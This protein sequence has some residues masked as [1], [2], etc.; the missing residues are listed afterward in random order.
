MKGVQLHFDDADNALEL[1]LKPAEFEAELKTADIF[2]LI[3][4]NG[5][6]RLYISESSVKAACEKANH[7]FKTKDLTDVVEKIGERRNAEVEFRIPEDAMVATVVLTTPYGGKLPTVDTIKK[8]AVKN[9]IKRGLGVK[10]IEALLLEA[11]SAPQGAIIEQIVAKGLPP[12]DGRPSKFVPL[13]PNALERVL[14]PQTG[15]D[16]R[17]DMRNLGE[18]ICVKANTEVLKRTAPTKGRTGFDVRGNVLEAKTGDWLDFKMGSGTEVSPKNENI[19]ISSIAGMPKYQNQVMNI[20][21]TFISNGVNVGTGHVNYE[22]A[23]LVNGDVTEKMVIKAKGDVTINGFVESAYIESGGDIIVTEGAMGKVNE[24]AAEFS[25][26]LVAAGSIH[27][28]HGQGIDLKCGQ[29]VTV[30][31]QLAYSRI[32]CGG[33][34]TVGQVDNPQGN[35]FACEIISQDKIIAGTLGAVSGSTLKVDFSSGYNL[36]LERRDALEDLLKQLRD[37]NHRHKEKIN[38]IKSKQVPAELRPRVDEVIDLYKS[39]SALLNWIE[40]RMLEMKNA[41]D[42]YQNSIG[43][44]ANKKLYSGVTVKLNNRSWRSEREYQR[45]KVY[46]ESHQWHY[47]PLV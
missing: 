9:N 8:L 29:N 20:D 35:L 45:A 14:R 27:V 22:G 2:S 33:S 16:G 23:V 28:Q 39:E 4:E 42:A 44:V 11:K 24:Q 10:R 6:D 19:L 13:V 17:V 18:V 37:N 15:K 36:L 26:Q 5:Y 21:D 40:T 32:F 31:R 34:V 30:T 43:L 3:T 25:C 1:T 7:F 47:E 41:K 46:Y 38:I 12:R